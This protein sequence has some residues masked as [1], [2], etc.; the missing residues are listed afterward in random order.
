MD[1][2][3]FRFLTLF[4]AAFAVAALLGRTPLFKVPSAISY[5]IFGL[6]LKLPALHLTPMDAWWLR[7]LGDLGL[8]FLM[9]LS[10][11]E[12]DVHLLFRKRD[13][14][15]EGTSP[16]V[17]GTMMFCA[18]LLFSFVCCASLAHFAPDGA[19][20]YMLSL[21]FATTS[22]GVVLPVLEETGYLHRP[23]GQAILYSAVIADFMTMLLVSLLLGAHKS[24]DPWQVWLTLAIVPIALGVGLSLEKLRQVPAAGRLLGQ[25]MERTRATIALVAIFAILAEATGSE[26]I[27]GAFLAGVIVRGLKFAHKPLVATYSYGV[28]YAVFVPMFFVAT[29]YAMPI[30]QLHAVRTLYWLPVFA[31]LAFTVKL[32]PALTLLRFHGKRQAWAAGFLL[33]SR[34]SLVAAAAQLAVN[35]HLLPEIWA[36]STILVS[37]ISSLIGPLAW[38]ILAPQLP[39]VDSR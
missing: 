17:I 37:I 16:A 25:A 24:E 11:M 7:R 18:T 10:G 6:L 19:N 23:L 39:P 34:L 27:L 28:G 31:V 9:F 33:S 5:L 26:P 12:I 8:L 14:H 30:A 38:A 20:P 36:A 22:L 1:A 13:D 35:A 21:L 15:K 29:G 32:L 4:V 2:T 3:M